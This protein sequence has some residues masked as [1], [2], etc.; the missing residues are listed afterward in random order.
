MEYETGKYVEP[1]DPEFPEKASETCTARHSGY[2]CCRR[3]GHEG[4]HVAV[5][6]EDKI[7]DVW[8]EPGMR[9]E[10]GEVF[11]DSYYRACRETKPDD[12]PFIC[13]RRRGHEGQHV[14]LDTEN[15]V[16]E[17]WE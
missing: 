11:P 5:T 17:V 1:G 13:C 8:Y 3:A 14:A 9:V 16:V 12:L 10:E 4:A 2:L 7:V 6:D 15:K